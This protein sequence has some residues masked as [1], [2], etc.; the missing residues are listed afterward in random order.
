MEVTA[1][2]QAY[3]LDEL[4]WSARERAVDS[5][6]RDAWNTLDTEDV[7]EE[8]HDQLSKLL[9]GDHAGYLSRRQLLDL[10]GVEVYWDYERGT[11]L[12]GTLRRSSAPALAWPFG[13]DAIHLRAGNGQSTSIESVTYDTE[14][15]WAGAK[16]NW[17]EA[18]EMLR[19]LLGKLDETMRAA[20]DARTSED[21]MVERYQDEPDQRR[22]NEYGQY[23]PV[24]FWTD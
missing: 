18:D 24:A 20:C 10:F 8:I 1:T 6:V 15:Y 16:D 11:S 14:C 19:D 22:Y 5:M 3:K 4:S 9:T 7:S 2:V 23:L 13:I 17:D 21:W 12:D